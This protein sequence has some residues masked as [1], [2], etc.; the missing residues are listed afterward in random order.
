MNIEV[1]S[2]W[3]EDEILFVRE[4]LTGNI[5]KCVNPWISNIVFEGLDYS[6]TEAVE[7]ITTTLRYEDE[8]N[9]GW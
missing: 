7:I 3:W 4:K 5:Y 8:D 1:E 9:K 6:S 2:F